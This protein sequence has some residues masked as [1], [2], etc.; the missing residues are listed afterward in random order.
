M[1]FP[2]LRPAPVWYH[3]SMSKDEV[4]S[5]RNVLVI[6]SEMGR[7]T[8]SRMRGVS[9]Y[10]RR[11]GWALNLEEGRHSGDHPD[12]AKWIGLWRPDGLIV[13]S[14]Y[15]ADVLSLD[16]AI[17][18]PAVFGDVVSESPLPAGCARVISDAAAI[19]A[20]AARELLRTGYPNFAFV[21]AVGDEPWSRNRA[22][23]FA[24]EMRGVGRK[25]SEYRP[26]PGAVDDTVRFRKGLAQF[27]RSLPTPC[28]VFAANDVT[29]S[30]VSWACAECGLEI[31][32]DVALVGVD[33]SEEFC[34]SCR[35]PT[36][37]IRL[38]FERCGIVMAELLGEMMS[39]VK[40][41]KSKVPS[42]EAAFGGRALVGRYGVERLVRRASTCVL[43]V[44]DGRVSRALEWIRLNA[45]RGI[46]VADVISEMGCSRSLADL[47]FRQAT[48]HTILGEIHS[49]RLD[50]AMSLLRQDD[51]PTAEIPDRCGYVRGPY[52]GILFKR[53]TGRTMRQWRAD[54]RLEN[55]LVD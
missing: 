15:L 51:I 32:S 43:R 55:R 27:M 26:E 3:L 24:A 38:D 9:A 19:A 36:T 31:P 21:P 33:D 18:P 28:G 30:L 52:L 42:R 12:F 16:P 40:S 10:A 44:R 45:T 4:D 25:V 53:T 46:D 39:K 29:A 13:D 22:A 41:R 35:P 49:R 7:L 1:E 11:A 48:G 20:T 54:W 5:G 50:A 6:V 2:A 14:D 8:Q 37:S 17:R 34:E 47:R 23:A